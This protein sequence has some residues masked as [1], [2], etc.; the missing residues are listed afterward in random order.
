MKRNTWILVAILVVLLAAAFFVLRQPGEVST[1]GNATGTLVQYDS[2]AVDK[3][4]I[5][6]PTG[7]I[8]L[9]LEGGKW[10]ILSPLHYPADQLSVTAAIGKGQRIELKNVVSSNP[11]KQQLFQVDSAGT[12]VRV[13][14]HGTEGA[15]FHVGKPGTSYTET[16]VRREG[17]NDVYLA[18]GLLTYTFSKSLK[19][20]RDRTV[21]KGEPDRITSVRLQFR[22]TT[23]ALQFKDSLWRVDGDSASQTAV[24]SFLGT[25][26]NLQADEFVDTAL[27]VSSAPNAVIEVEGVQI[28]FYAAKDGGKYSIQTSAAPQWF[29]VQ[30]WRAAEVLK[31]KKDFLAG[32]R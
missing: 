6:S 4:E 11:Q 5:T 21:F 31:R 2:A 14:K 24:R 9:A 3:L 13:F 7:A 26:A 19:D 17:S 15:A 12:L 29:E 28:R 22:D 1:S 25:L 18:D 32:T 27:T 23:F 10:M 30:G 20:W 16:Y 8:T